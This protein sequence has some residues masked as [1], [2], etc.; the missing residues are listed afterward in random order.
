MIQEASKYM[1]IRPAHI[2]TLA[3]IWVE[4]TKKKFKQKNHHR[5]G[6]QLSELR[7]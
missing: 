6:N 2:W 3:K 4:N 7:C 5:I 1:N